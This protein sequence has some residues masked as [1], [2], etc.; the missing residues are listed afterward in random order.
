MICKD[1]F[2]SKKCPEKER[3]FNTFSGTP[4]NAGCCIGKYMG[5]ECE[6]NAPA[7]EVIDV[8]KIVSG[9]DTSIVVAEEFEGPPACFGLTPPGWDA[10]NDSFCA[11][12]E[13]YDVC[14]ETGPDDSHIVIMEEA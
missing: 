4:Q 2:L 9:A 7:C 6:D 11:E 1:C 12:C 14:R 8:C 5:N 10:P 3:T 13:Y